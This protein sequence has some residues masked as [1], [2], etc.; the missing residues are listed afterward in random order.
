MKAFAFRAMDG[1][2]TFF[3][4]IPSA[5]PPACS[6]PHTSAS[7]CG[8]HS[9]GKQSSGLF[10]DP[11]H[12]M[13]FIW[14]TMDASVTRQGFAAQKP[15]RACRHT[16]PAI[17][18][19]TRSLSWFEGKPLPGNGI[20]P[21]SRQSSDTRCP[22]G[23]CAA[24]TERGHAAFSLSQDGD[25]LRLCVSACLHSKSP[26]ASCREN[27][28]FAAPYF[29]GDYHLTA[30]ML[31][32]ARPTADSCNHLLFNAPGILF[33]NAGAWIEASF[34]KN[35]SGNDAAFAVKT[36]F[37]AQPLIWLQG[38]DDFSFKISPNRSTFLEAIV[39]DHA[40]GQVHLQQPPFSLC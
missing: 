22:A 10:S 31:G 19:T 15:E 29:R 16:S 23:E 6:G 24:F 4:G 13:A 14:L 11:P 21:C 32:I 2:V 36:G 26:H 34:N 35:T 18:K 27:S 17:C 33:N 37:S 9:A 7:A 40:N 3:Q 12:S 5:N 38:S 8:S 20:M 25:D 30:Q 39:V 1:P 28:T